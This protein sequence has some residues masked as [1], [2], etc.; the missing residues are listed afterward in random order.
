MFRTRWRIRASQQ[1]VC[2]SGRKLCWF[3][4]E[5]VLPIRLAPRKRPRAKSRAAGQA[6][7][8]EAGGAHRPCVGLCDPT[9]LL[10]FCLNY[11]FSF[12]FANVAPRA[13]N[14]TP[15]HPSRH[16]AH[17]SN[18]LVAHMTYK[19]QL[20]IDATAAQCRSMK[21]LHTHSSLPLHGCTLVEA[22]G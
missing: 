22:V 7:Q 20:H 12:Y 15:G 14:D 2:S 18:R 17:R 4:Q 5:R 19:I 8:Q 1:R 6:H 11:L 13:R 21:Q 9:I 10:P 3:P 16:A